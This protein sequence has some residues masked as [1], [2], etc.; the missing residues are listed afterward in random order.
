MNK[1]MIAAVNAALKGE[2]Y[3]NNSGRTYEDYAN[4]QEGLKEILR[5][6]QAA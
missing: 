4:P 1:D 5:R 3:A 6:L 2:L